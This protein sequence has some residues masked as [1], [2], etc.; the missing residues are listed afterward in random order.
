MFRNATKSLSKMQVLLA[1]YLKSTCSCLCSALHFFLR[2]MDSHGQSGSSSSRTGPNRECQNQERASS[3]SL[4]RCT[5][6]R[7]SSGRMDQSLSTAGLSQL[8]TDVIQSAVLTIGGNL[9]LT[10]GV[11]CTV[12]ADSQCCFVFGKK[13]LT[14]GEYGAAAHASG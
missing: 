2:R 8:W 12:R 6:P 9:A 11:T 5:K 1:G 13:H 4:G 14:S 7:S 10:H 3:I